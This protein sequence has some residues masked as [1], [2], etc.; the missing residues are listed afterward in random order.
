[1]NRLLLSLLFCFP[2]SILFAVD[3]KKDIAPILKAQCYKCHSE[4]AKKEKGGYVFDNL[5]RLA[6]DIGPGRVIEPGDLE[7]SHLYGTLVSPEDDDAH[8]PRGKTLDQADIAKFKQWIM[9]GASLDGGKKP[10]AGGSAPGGLP[11]RPVMQNWTNTDGR[12]IQ[13]SMLRME[14][15]NVMLQ[16]ANGQTYPYPMSKLSA[17]S[18]ALAKRGGK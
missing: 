7:A 6:K 9:D 16:M 13:A 2:A 4:E 18:Q 11:T 17:D 5:T 8:M 14:G 1:M 10:T 15:D 3:F 12:I